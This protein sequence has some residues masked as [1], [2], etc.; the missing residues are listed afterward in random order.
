MGRAEAKKG[1]RWRL[2]TNVALSCVALGFVIY[3]GRK[4][5]QFVTTDSRFTLAS[6]D[7]RAAGLSMRG[8]VHASRYRVLSAFSRD[9]GRSVF[10]VPVA[11]RRR[12]LLAVDWVGGAYIARVWRDQ[13][14][15]RMEGRR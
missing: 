14:E 1:I 9:F 4:V 15:G 13:G 6:P 3:A 12:R 10:L 5:R 7:D 8:L 11:E 2:W